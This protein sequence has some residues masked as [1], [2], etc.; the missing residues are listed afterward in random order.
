MAYV[1]T[2]IIPI[3]G[4]DNGHLGIDSFVTTVANLPYARIRS[5]VVTWSY[6]LSHSDIAPIDSNGLPVT[7]VCMSVTTLGTIS[8]C[9]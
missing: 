9:G 3:L 5:G 7:V 1:R 6:D 8:P 4:I 2:V